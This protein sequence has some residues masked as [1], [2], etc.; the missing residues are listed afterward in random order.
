MWRW[1]CIPYLY[2][3]WGWRYGQ[4]S[5]NT[6]WNVTSALRTGMC[7]GRWT[8]GDLFSAEQLY[9]YMSLGT[10]SWRKKYLK[11]VLKDGLDFNCKM[12][13]KGLGASNRRTCIHKGIA[14]GRH[15]VELQWWVHATLSQLVERLSPSFPLFPLDCCA[16]GSY[17]SLRS[18]KRTMKWEVG[19]KVVVGFSSHWLSLLFYCEHL[20]RKVKGKITLIAGWL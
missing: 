6:K 17:Y 14:I 18:W 20:A 4:L 3:K 5:S 13:R 9:I 2:S 12:L 16:V 1:R 19:L 11:W 7:N 8:T 15:H 10:F